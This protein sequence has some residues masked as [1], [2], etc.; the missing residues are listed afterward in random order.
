M[1]YATFGRGLDG[2]RF[3]LS[4]NGYPWDKE[5]IDKVNWALAEANAAGLPA[6]EA[7]NRGVAAM[8]PYLAETGGGAVQNLDNFIKSMGAD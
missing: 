1:F 5:V 6:H 3:Q 4:F 8:L 7:V 2:A